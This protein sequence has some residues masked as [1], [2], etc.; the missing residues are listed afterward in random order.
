[1]AKSTSTSRQK[2]RSSS[3]PSKKGQPQQQEPP[4][5]QRAQAVLSKLEKRDPGLKELLKKAHGYAIFP[6][7]GK[8][9]L[10]VGGSYG[11]GVVFEKRRMIGYATISQMTIG[12]QIGGDT[13]TEILVFHDEKQLERFKKGHM[14]F[15]A[16]ASAVMVKAAAAGTSD[17]KGV[18]AL[19]YSSGGMLLELA[20]G[21]QKFTFKPLRGGGGEEQEGGSK[22]QGRGAQGRQGAAGSES[23]EDE[24]GGENGAGMLGRAVG[25]LSKVSGMA[26]DHPIA[27]TVLGAGLTTGLAFLLVR[28]IRS[29]GGGSASGS[30]SD[31]DDQD[32]EEWDDDTDARDESDAD[33][34]DDQEEDADEDEEEGEEDRGGDEDEEED[35]DSGGGSRLRRR[36]RTR[37]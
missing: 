27:T 16:N 12:V 18:T 3:S 10:V 7:V 36:S 21:G 33:D 13:F 35:E 32:E 5:R 22:G 25:G 6:S 14:A 30:N 9:A 20:L 1:M 31:S 24:T 11:R 29:S 28:A 8:A 15:A 4:L 2:S 26:K 34:A 19:A 17:F 37:A 23:G